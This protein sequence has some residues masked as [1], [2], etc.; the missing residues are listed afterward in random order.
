M[1]LPAYSYSGHPKH[2]L[3][4]KLME[5]L[6]TVKGNLHQFSD[7]PETIGMLVQLSD[8]VRHRLG[9]YRF[10]LPTT[11]RHADRLDR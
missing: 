11:Y 9:K 2:D 5:A 1:N 4:V 10:V 6:I 3:A 7:D 8:E